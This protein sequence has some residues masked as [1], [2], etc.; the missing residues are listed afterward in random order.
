MFIR[1]NRA[2]TYMYLKYL[3]IVIKKEVILDFAILFQALK[4]NKKYSIKLK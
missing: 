4:H 3:C 2:F 1:N